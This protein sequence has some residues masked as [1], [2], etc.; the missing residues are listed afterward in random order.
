MASHSHHIVFATILAVI[1]SATVSAQPPFAER[2]KLVPSEQEQAQVTA[3]NKAY[4]DSFSGP[5]DENWV[6]QK[7]TSDT[8]GRGCWTDKETFYSVGEQKMFNGIAMQCVEIGRSTRVFWPQRWIEFCDGI[9][10][11][12][13]F[14][15]MQSFEFD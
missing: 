7:I 12:Y 8:L 2:A 1:F 9:E 5:K 4:Y 10:M 11:D 13:G 14:C 3:V 6:M 15:M